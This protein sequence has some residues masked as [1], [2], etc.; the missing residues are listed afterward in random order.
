MSD[1]FRARAMAASIKVFPHL[2]WGLKRLNEI[3][4]ANKACNKVIQKREVGF[5]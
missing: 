2:K 1:A 5:N 3:M 4:C